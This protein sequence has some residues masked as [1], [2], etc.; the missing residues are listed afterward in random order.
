MDKQR[1]TEDQVMLNR[2]IFFSNNLSIFDSDRNTVF[3]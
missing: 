1:Y 3:V 2:K